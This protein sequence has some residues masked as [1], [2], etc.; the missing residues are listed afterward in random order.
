MTANLKFTTANSNSNSPWQIQIRHGKFKFTAANSNSPWQIQIH[1]SKFKIHHGKFKFTTIDSKSLLTVRFA[2]G[3]GLVLGGFRLFLVVHA[4]FCWGLRDLL[5]FGVCL[6]WG[7]YCFLCA[8]VILGFRGCRM[9]AG[10]G[11]LSEVRTLYVMHSGAPLC[12]ALVGFL[13]L[14]MVEAGGQMEASG[15]GGPLRISGDGSL[16]WSVCVVCWALGYLDRAGVQ[17]FWDWLMSTGSCPISYFFFIVPY[18]V[19]SEGRASSFGFLSTV[20]YL[21]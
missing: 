18:S 1:H 12:L 8:W 21:T 15:A 4:S 19:D 3:V 13:P 5:G 7:L 20:K 14:A 6:I 10:S 9:W 17:T 2:T 16:F 11:H